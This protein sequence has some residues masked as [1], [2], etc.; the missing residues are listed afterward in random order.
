M[1]EHGTDR[2]MLAFLRLEALPPFRRQSLVQGEGTDLA[3]SR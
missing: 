1:A 2:E 3:P